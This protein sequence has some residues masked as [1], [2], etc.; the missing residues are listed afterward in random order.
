[1]LG[2]M[3]W[4][5]YQNNRYRF[6][7]RTDIP[8]VKEGDI[9]TWGLEKIVEETLAQ[10]RLSLSEPD[11]SKSTTIDLYEPILNKGNSHRQEVQADL[12]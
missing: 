6:N 9:E 5:Y 12:I 3:Y 11:K 8:S 7:N 1:M 4:Q 10:Y 2:E